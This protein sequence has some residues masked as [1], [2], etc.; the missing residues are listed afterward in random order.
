MPVR[1]TL[2]ASGIAST[3]VRP[4]ANCAPAGRPPFIGDNRHIIL[5]V[6][7]DAEGMAVGRYAVSIAHCDF[8]APPSLV[9]ISFAGVLPLG[10]AFEQATHIGKRLLAVV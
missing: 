5:R 10:Y 8:P 4:E 2:C 6:D 7:L 9:S 1:A 3:S